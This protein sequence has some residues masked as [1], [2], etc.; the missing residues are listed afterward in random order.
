M[1][2]LTFRKETIQEI[3][4]DPPLSP[5][6]F[7]IPEEVRQ[8]PELGERRISQWLLRRVS[9]GVSYL[10][11]ARPQSVDWEELEPHLYFN[12][13][14]PHTIPWIFKYYDRSWG[15]CLPKLTFDKLDQTV[16]YRAVIRSEFTIDPE[17]GFRVASTRRPRLL[18][19]R[20]RR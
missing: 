12:E 10:D 3:A 11:F 9:M 19:F 20:R 4:N 6:T 1:N 17:N 18:P 8:E 14:L 15:F 7:A 5:E 2:G 13:K 16:K